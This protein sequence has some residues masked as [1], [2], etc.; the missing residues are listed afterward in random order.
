MPNS[1]PAKRWNNFDVSDLAD[2]LNRLRIHMREI[3]AQLFSRYDFHGT[4]SES[5]RNLIHYLVLR[6]HDLCEIQSRLSALGLSSLGR[7]ES[8]VM[9]AIERLVAILEHISESP[10]AMLFH[11]CATIPA[12]NCKSILEQR[13]TELL[14][15]KVADRNARIMATVPS[16]AAWNYQLVHDLVQHGMDCMRINCVYDNPDLWM[17]MIKNLKRACMELKRP[18]SVLMDVPGPKVRTGAIEPGIKVVKIKAHRD[19]LGRITAPVRVWLKPVES[20]TEAPASADA[21]LQVPGDWLA[22][23]AEGDKIKFDDARGASRSLKITGVEGNGRWAAATET[24]YIVPET[25]LRLRRKESETLSE[26]ALVTN[27]QNIRGKEQYLRLASGDVL[28][29]TNLGMPGRPAVHNEE[30]QL[31]TPATISI[32]PPKVFN[33]IRPGEAV[34]FDDG[35]IGGIIRSVESSQVTVEITYSANG[36]EKLGANKGVNLPDTDLRLPALT[37]RD[38]ET[39]EFIVKNADMVGYS[40]AASAAGLKEL[41]RRLRGMGGE[42]LGIILKIET[43]KAFENLPELLLAGLERSKVGVMIARGDLAVEC[44]FERLAEL[45]EEILWLCEAAH[46]PVIW[47]TQVLDSLAKDGLPSRAEITDAAMA[48][49]ADCVMLNKGPHIIHTLDTLND[50]LLRMEAHQNKK[51][52]ILRRLHLAEKYAQNALSNEAMTYGAHEVVGMSQPYLGC[53]K[54]LEEEVRQ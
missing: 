38:V 47:A 27:V 1:L 14:G 52:S 34:W 33:D 48:S 18:C 25:K 4:Y 23:A 30:G 21:V 45:Q 40:Y 42:N 17:Q 3:E 43:R 32:T 22:Q 29:L 37:D 20:S 24:A 35:R 5:A 28:I 54:P 36:G 46:M 44:G 7:C 19:E 16:E 50:I 8:E 51:R 15:P 9:T 31:I 49:R 26:A 12:N 6:E 10:A 53:A 13:T 41:Q 2:H 11:P 39:L